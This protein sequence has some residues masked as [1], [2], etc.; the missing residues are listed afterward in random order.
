MVNPKKIYGV[1]Y[2]LPQEITDNLFK[3]KRDIFV[4][5]LGVSVNKKSKISLREGMKVYFY[6]SGSNKSIIGEGKIKKIYF[7]NSGEI[8]SKYKNRI[9]F[10]LSEFKT[11]V[12][13]RE[14]KN[15]MVLELSHLKP[16]AIPIIL[17]KPINMGGKYINTKTKKFMGL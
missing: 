4:K 11:Y 15:A 6:A 7:L 17:N 2:S 5:Y 10:N 1:V 13:D 16:Y 12:R 8:L 9:M 14:R 3:K